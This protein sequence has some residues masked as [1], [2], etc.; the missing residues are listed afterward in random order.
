MIECILG[1]ICNTSCLYNVQNLGNGT[2]VLTHHHHH[3][4]LLSAYSVPSIFNVVS[5]VIQP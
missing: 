2:C 5:Y 4:Y 1:H 3:Q